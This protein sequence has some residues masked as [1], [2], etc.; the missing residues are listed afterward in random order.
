MRELYSDNA[1]WQPLYERYWQIEPPLD[2]SSCVVAASDDTASSAMSQLQLYRQRQRQQFLQKSKNYFQLF[3]SVGIDRVRRA[4]DDATV[5]ILE[6]NITEGGGAAGN[7]AR[8]LAT[9]MD[10]QRQALFIA[11]DDGSVRMVSCDGRTEIRYRWMTEEESDSDAMEIT[12]AAFSPFALEVARTRSVAFA[13]GSSVHLYSFTIPSAEEEAEKVDQNIALKLHHR[14]RYLASLARWSTVK[15]VA[16]VR[17]SSL[18]MSSKALVACS[19]NSR[20]T[21]VFSIED[22]QMENPLSTP[23]PISILAGSTAAISAENRM[24]SIDSGTIQWNVVIE[25][26]ENVKVKFMKEERRAF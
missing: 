10:V 7:G 3:H 14:K 6:I 15:T 12:A 23:T 25:N 13:R 9:E 4:I 1:L 2:V 16:D 21:Q 19:V 18:S 11:C 20:T 26:K 8:I 24:M 5:Q 22:D 17:F